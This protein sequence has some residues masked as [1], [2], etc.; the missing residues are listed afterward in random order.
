M[1]YTLGQRHG[2]GIGG[3]KD[4]GDEPWYVAAKD[5]EHNILRVVQGVEHPALFSRQLQASQLHWIAGAPPSGCFTATAK[6]RYRQADQTCHVNL[7]PDDRCQVEFAEPQR[8][9]T[10]GQSVVFYNHEIC[11]G[12]GVIETAMP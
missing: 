3:R 5:M 6:I 10:P 7:Q 9:I 2:L 8:A 11:L 12:G 1:F 4:A